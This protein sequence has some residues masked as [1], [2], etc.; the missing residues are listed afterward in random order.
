[1]GTRDRQ[2]RLQ[3][4]LYKTVCMWCESKRASLE[5]NRKVHLGGSDSIR[6]TA[7]SGLCSTYKLVASV[8]KI[9]GNS[10]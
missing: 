8:L 9:L 5:V 7:Y 3:Q 4:A 10:W 2:D 1:M 6:R